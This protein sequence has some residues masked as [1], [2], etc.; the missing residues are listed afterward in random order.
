MSTQMPAGTFD[1]ADLMAAEYVLGVL[2]AGEL[3]A[4]RRRLRTEPAF[5]GEVSRW[6][7][8]FLPWIDSVAPVQAP[9]DAWARLRRQLGWEGRGASEARMPTPTRAPLLGFWKTLTYSSLALAAVCA[10]SLAWLLRQPPEVAPAPPP[11]VVTRILVPDMVAKIE[12]DSGRAMLVAS[13]DS[14][15]GEMSLAP[16]DDMSVPADRAAE[17]WLIP[18]GG[19]PQSL[20]VIDP[21]Q[22]A[23]MTIPDAMR[24][25]LG[26][27]ALLAVS[28]EPLGGSPTGQ[29]TGPVVAK[30]GMRGV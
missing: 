19:A 29:P 28:V 1:D 5:A 17:L 20:G 30:G 7:S 14:T 8:Y 22:A 18:A 24:A 21:S 3:R 11:E 2:D 4:A 23:T 9:A 26:T 10:L 12:D 27:E 25:G 15:S 16:V 13:I 6:E